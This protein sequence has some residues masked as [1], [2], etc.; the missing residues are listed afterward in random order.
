MTGTALRGLAAAFLIL[1][2]TAIA[3]AAEP[4]PW[5][6]KSTAFETDPSLLPNGLILVA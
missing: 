6:A 4:A 2:T 1:L 5:G 3:S